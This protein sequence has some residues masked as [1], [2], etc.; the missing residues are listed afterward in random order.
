MVRKLV[1]SLIAVMGVCALAFAQNKQISGTVVDADGLPIIGATVMVDGTSVGTSTGADGS[2]TLPVPANGSLLIS[3]IGYQ[4]LTL[5]V[6]GR[7]HVEVTLKSD[8]TTIDNVVVV[9]YGSGSK[10]G[11]AIGSSVKVQGEQL[12]NKPVANVADALQGKVA[13]L[14]VYTSSGEPSQTSSMRL[15]G[16]GS[17]TAGTAPL[18]VLD[19]VPI[20]QE[21]MLSLNSNDIESMTMLKDASATSIYGSRAANGVL[22]I[23]MKKGRRGEQAKIV[24]NA[25]YG[26]SQPVTGKYDVMNTL[27]LAEYE[28]GNDLINQEIFDKRMEA[29]IDT[30]WKKF[31]YR[32]AAPTSQADISVTGGTDNT[33]YYI[34]GGYMS[35]DGTAPRSNMTKYSFRTNVD[36]SVASWARIGSSVALGYDERS[37]AVPSGANTYSANFMSLMLRPDISAYNEDGSEPDKYGQFTNP[38]LAARKTPSMGRKLQLNANAYVQITPIKGLNIKS[39]I[40]VDGLWYTSRQTSLPSFIDNPNNGSVGRTHQDSQTLSITNTI[41]Y[42]FSFANPDHRLYLLAG[43]EGIKSSET[44]FNASRNG[45]VRDDLMMISTGVGTPSASDGYTSYLFNSWFGRA[46]YSFASK[47]I[48]DATVRRDASSRFGASNRSAVFYS[49][50]FMWDAKRELF[51]YNNKTITDLSFK[52]SYGTQGNASIPNYAHQSLLNMGTYNDQ[53]AFYL[54]QY[55]NKDLGWETQQLLTVAANIGLWDRLNIEL[56]FYNRIT[57]DMLMAVP[58]PSTSGYGSRYENVGSMRNRGI[59]VTLDAAIVRTQDWAVNFHATFSYGKSVITKLF[60]GYDEYAMPDYGLCYKVGHDAGEFYMPIRVGID[61][62]D[63]RQIWETID[64]KTGEMGTTKEFEQATSQLVGKSRYAPYSGGFGISAGWKGISLSADFSWNYGKY[65]NNNTRYFLESPSNVGTFNRS[66]DLKHEWRQPGDVTD[67]PKFGEAIQFDTH[68]LEDASFL[69]LKNLTVGYDFPKTWMAKTGVISGLRVYFTA[70]NLLTF[71]S[72]SGYDPEV[73][74]NNAL[75][76]Y[77]NSRQFVG[78]IQITF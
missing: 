11:T 61:P 53:A 41:D 19:G 5:P 69:R 16:V 1:L 28:L 3:F 66:S 30:N 42:N 49:F 55:G 25:Q 9:G 70:R 44:Q 43:Q 60:N 39:M 35:Q 4:S 46:E 58:M 14:Q 73:D 24:V 7:T 62:E 75:G 12:A 20:G 29:G 26:I 34:A 33:A 48:A 23:T 47:Y 18:L 38:N 56:E 71:T 45:Q 63:G 37:N 57:K 31:F 65:L 40:G 77:P 17:L 72:F 51:L 64:P 78:G 22:Y 10:V 13:G 68:L 52:V 36:S 8:E 21:A 54:A 59:D 15:H 6:A 76:N 50:G 74:S 2:F 27:E 32:N 67:V